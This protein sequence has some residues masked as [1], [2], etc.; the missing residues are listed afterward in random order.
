MVTVSMTEGPEET[1]SSCV[2]GGASGSCGDGNVA[3]G[4]RG[5]AW[6]IGSNRDVDADCIF[7]EVSRLGRSML[8]ETLGMIIEGPADM[9]TLR[10]E[11]GRVA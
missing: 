10:Y 3:T 6:R 1:W 8:C 11:S 4:F 7:G 9:M 2:G 5:L